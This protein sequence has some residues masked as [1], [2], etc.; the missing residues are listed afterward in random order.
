MSIT[1]KAFKQ[2]SWLA[3]FKFITQ[4]ISWATTIIIA[5]L[6][7]PDDYGLMDMATILTAYAAIFSELGLGAAIIQRQD[8]TQD[9]LSSVFWFTFLVSLFFGGICFVLA[10]PT[11]QIFNEPRVIPLT[12]TVSVIFILN[13]LAIVPVNL[14][15]KK[16]NF[17]IIGAIEMTSGL[18]SCVGML[19]IAKYG[20]GVWTLLLGHIIR[21]FV[22]LLLVTLWQKWYPRLYFNFHDVKSYLNFGIVVA[23]GRTFRYLFEKADIFFAG[24]VWAVSNLGLYSFAILLARL[25][26]DKIVSLIMQV[27]FSAFS[28]LQHDRKEFNRFYLNINKLIFILVLPLFV[29]GFLAGEELIKVFLDDKW[30][31]IV[32]LFKMLCIS[33]IFLAIT[34]INNHV[35]T[36]Q[37][38]PGW[39]MC[40]NAVCAVTMSIAFYF[41]VSYGLK[42]ILI[43]W[44]TIFPLL[45]VAFIFLTLKKINVRIREYLKMM[46]VPVM[47]T[48]VMSSVVIFCQYIILVVSPV[49]SQEWLIL[50]AK[51]ISGGLSYLGFLFVFDRIFLQKIYQMF[52]TK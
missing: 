8:I 2:G 32:F 5:R 30:F 22:N 29:G 26:T 47:A 3:V 14:M 20:G 40:F 1:Q 10:Y 34:A 50:C 31:S 23:I 11:A 18:A 12:Q 24:M 37:G 25:P 21:S 19:L 4:I 28:E 41:C 49:F 27:S 16:L 35:H 38:R 15:K 7:V 51:V 45:C 13:G 46:L 33:Q 36:A 17:K 42:A 9:G 43:P 39:S 52:R 48:I 6:L 44:L